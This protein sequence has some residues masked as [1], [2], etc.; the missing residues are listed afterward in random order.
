LTTGARLFVSEEGLPLGNLGSEFLNDLAEQTATIKLGKLHPKSES[1]SVELPEG[2]EASL[3]IDVNIPPPELMIFGAGHDAIPVAKFAGDLGIRTVVVDPRS[4][5]AT[6]ENFPGAEIVLARSEELE[7]K[8]WPGKRT[9]TVIMNHHLERDQACLRFALESNAPYIGVLGPRKRRKWLLDGLEEQGITFSEEQL[10]RMY[11]PI[12]LDIGAE[13]SEEVAI[14]ILSE[15]LAVRNGHTGEF[16][17]MK[18]RI[19]QP[20]GE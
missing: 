19:H 10:S 1:H 14:S 12:G 11:N 2:G 4:A 13:T 8:V 18:G 7:D 9:F 6:E 3:F 17:R 15:I 5:F 20:V 16:L